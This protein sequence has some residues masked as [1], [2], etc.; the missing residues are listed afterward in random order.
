MAEMFL[1]KS[2]HWGY[3]YVAMVSSFQEHL[4]ILPIQNG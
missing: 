3:L 4:K 1:Q 2:S